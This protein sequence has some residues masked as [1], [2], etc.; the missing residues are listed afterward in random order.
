M[1]NAFIK[2]E[3]SLDEF[4]IQRH[5]YNIFKK[6]EMELLTNTRVVKQEVTDI[7]ETMEILTEIVQRQ[8]QN[9]QELRTEL[10]LNQFG[11]YREDAFYQSGET[12]NE[13]SP[14]PPSSSITVANNERI[15][16][17]M[18]QLRF[19]NCFPLTIKVQ[20]LQQ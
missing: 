14:Q 15:F 19:E 13:Q 10:K 9:I 12:K 20:I 8:D 4:E 7:C 3:N 17:K 5:V 18:T 6:D 1:D 2:M 16:D 11:G